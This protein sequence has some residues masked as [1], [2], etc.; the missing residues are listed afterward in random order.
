MDILLGTE[1]L[2]SVYLQT[3]PISASFVKWP[4]LFI[5][6][7]LTIL[8]KTTVGKT[9]IRTLI[10]GVK[11]CPLGHYSEPSKLEKLSLILPSHIGTLRPGPWGRSLVM[12]IHFWLKH[13]IYARK[14]FRKDGVKKGS[15]KNNY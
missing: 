4:L 7:L 10:V 5:F 13:N 11:G 6:F 1:I 15:R 8:Q 12:T 14:T 3:E 9:G 2:F